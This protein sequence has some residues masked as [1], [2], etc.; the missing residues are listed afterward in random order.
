MADAVAFG[1]TDGQP[2]P[3]QCAANMGVE[4]AIGGR[5]EAFGGA[6]DSVDVIVAIVEE[7]AH[8]LPGACRDGAAFAPQSLIERGQPLMGLAV[9]RVQ[10]QEGAGKGGRVGAH[11]PQVGQGRRGISEDRIGQRLAHVR[12]QP[13]GIARAKLGHV[14]A[15]LLHEAKHHAGGDRAIV[16]LHLVEIGQRNAELGGEILLRQPEP[17]AQFAQLG[18]G[19]EFLNGHHIASLLQS[20]HGICKAALQGVKRARPAVR[21]TWCRGS[22]RGPAPTRS[23]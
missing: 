5:G 19:I 16:V 6:V 3:C 22:P 2:A 8:L 21:D 18:P 10:F 1:V 23:A 14:E 17:P 7:I 15:E 12:D 4:V 20:H 11:K 13:F 9:G